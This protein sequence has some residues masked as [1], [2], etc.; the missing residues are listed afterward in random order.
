MSRTYAVIGTDARQVWLASLLKAH[1]LSVISRPTPDLFADVMIL[2]VPSVTKDGMLAGTALPF[3]EFLRTLPQGAE[4]WGS[5]FSPFLGCAEEQQLT[6]KD[7]TAFEAF[8]EDNARPTAEGAVQ[9][10]MEELPVTIRGSRFLVIGYGRIGKQLAALLAAMGGEVTVARQKGEASPFRT[11]ITGTYI[12]PLE[13]YHAIF[14]TV[15]MPVL[16]ESQ[17]LQT[18]GDCLLIDLASQPG[19]IAKTQTRRLIHALGLP[20]KTSPKTAAEIMLR[21]LLN[22]TEE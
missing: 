22:E 4:L 14:N 18:A 6:L 1:K 2:P 17:C 15:P 16:N 8:A 3:P 11:D 5:G 12:Y 19:G 9:L 13:E 7:F 21:I 20:A 10:A